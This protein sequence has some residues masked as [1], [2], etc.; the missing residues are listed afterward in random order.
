MATPEENR[1][2]EIMLEAG[3]TQEHQPVGLDD[4]NTATRLMDK[5]YSPLIVRKYQ[6]YGWPLFIALIC[7]VSLSN[8]DQVVHGFT[9][10]YGGK[11]DDIQWV[12]NYCGGLSDCLVNTYDEVKPGCVE[13]VAV[14]WYVDKMFCS[15]LWGDFMVHAS[16]KQELFAIINTLPHI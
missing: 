16:C 6:M 9:K 15:S 4:V 3:L 7:D 13:G 14:L 8:L 2:R 12:R 10:A 5:N 11:E 1:K